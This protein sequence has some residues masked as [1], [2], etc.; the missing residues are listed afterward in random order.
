M[1]AIKNSIALMLLRFE[2]N[3]GLRRFLWANIVIQVLLAMYNMLSQLLICDPLHK[4]WDLTGTVP[5]TCWSSEAIRDNLICQ[6]SV[7]IVTDIILALMP[8]SFLRKVKRPMRERVIVGVLMGLGILA[9]AASMAKV[10]AAIRIRQVGD[11]TAVGI[12]VGMWSAVEELTAFICACVPCLRSPFQRLLKHFGVISSD[13][14][15]S[16]QGYYN[17]GAGNFASA[18]GSEQRMAN[19]HMVNKSI[20]MKSMRSTTADA[21]SD[22]MILS[23]EATGDGDGIWRTTEVVVEGRIKPPGFVDDPHRDVLSSWDDKSPTS[24]SSSRRKVIA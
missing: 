12:Q 22:T 11:A 2:T 15:S 5:G 13:K 7:F 9:S 3:I 18:K 4:V 10:Q 6:S 24:E 14:S 16:A 17:M 19:D 23:E 21:D 8:I 1:A 20:K